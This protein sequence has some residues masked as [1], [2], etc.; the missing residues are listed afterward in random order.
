MSARVRK[1]FDDQTSLVEPLALD[2][3]F[4]DVTVPAPGLTLPL[5][6]PSRYA[7]RFHLNSDSAVRWALPPTSLLRNWR[8]LM[9]S[10]WHLRQV[11]SPALALSSWMR[12][13]SMTTCNDSTLVA[14]GGWSEVES[15]T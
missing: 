13:L 14:C 15:K 7:N 2:E 8:Q 11:F 10:L 6:L 4:L 5:D 9:P 3:A 1:I 12:E